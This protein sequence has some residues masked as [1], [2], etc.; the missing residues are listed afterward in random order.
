[1]TPAGLADPL[2]FARQWHRV[3][4]YVLDVALAVLLRVP[5]AGLL[6]GFVILWLTPQAQDLFVDLATADAQT[7]VHRE[8]IDTGSG[9]SYPAATAHPCTRERDP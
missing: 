5:V 7:R 2:R 8:H 9:A 3:W 1:M 6:F 4:A